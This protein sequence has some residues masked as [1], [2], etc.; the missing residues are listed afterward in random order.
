ML[1]C[2]DFY[3]ALTSHGIDFFCGVPDSLL[4]DF[5][6][7]IT[8]TAKPDKHII[9]ANEGN[10]IA[11]ASG[12]Y[13]STGI[14]AVVYMQNSGQG[15]AVNPLVSLADEDVYQI[16]MLLIIGW[17]GEPGIKDE[18]QHTK[19][20]KI[21]LSLLDTLNIPYSI[22]PDNKSDMENFVDKAISEMRISNKPY[23]LIVKKG[24]FEAY[25][26]Q[27]KTSNNYEMTR[28]EAI[29]IIVDNLGSTDAVISTTGMSS[30]ELYEYR[31]ALGQSGSS[32]FLTVGS[33]G[34]SSSIAL[35]I[36]INKPN[37]QVICI[38]G[39]GAAIMHLGAFTTIGT[40]APTN[41]KHILINN[42]A[43]DSVGGQSTC[44]F[45][46]DFCKIAQACRYKKVL[47][48]TNSMELSDKLEILK[49]ADGPVFLEVKVKKGARN[50][51]GRP[52]SS[53]IENKEKFMEFLR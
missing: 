6:A 28:E 11:L 46:I 39:D 27:N 38:D 50:D 44:G 1:N 25:K 10:A 2:A 43:H 30:R 26:L 22:L 17:R 13:L 3:N 12:V 31:Q 23:A 36:A 53:P 4:K 40:K 29:K 16:P 52:K 33:M 45:D 48:A 51:L 19:Q 35:G 18:P 34:H 49:T 41:F 14:P 21:T 42:G 32:D 8:D 47:S 37:I 5:C 7:Y 15:N 9:T 24:T 20:G